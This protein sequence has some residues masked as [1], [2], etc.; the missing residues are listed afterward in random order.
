MSS[1]AK[2]VTAYIRETEQG[3]TPA[4]DWNVLRRTSFGVKPSYGTNESNEIGE[5]RMAQSTSAGTIDVGG[6][7][8]TMLR[9]GALDDFLA[10]CFGAEWRDN[11]LTMGDDNITF[12]IA[13]AFKDIGVQAVARGCRVGKME[14]TFPGDNDITVTTT[15]AGRDF[16]SRQ[17]DPFYTG[18]RNTADSV[19][20]YS[21]KDVSGLTMDGLPLEGVACVDNFSLSFDNNVQAQRCLGNG[22][23]YPGN[24]IA[25]KFAPT[26]SITLAWSPRAYEIWARQREKGTV[27]FAFTVRNA[28]GEYRFEFPRM[29][30]SGDWPDGG[31][32]D[33]VQVTLNVSAVVIPPKITRAPTQQ[34]K[35]S[36]TGKNGASDKPT[37]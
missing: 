37:A 20:N 11:T 16:E 17:G 25:T 7:V 3:K 14:F 10:S 12:S 21:F 23:G 19:P 4:G 15:F 22:T 5:S 35:G 24:Q 13:E 34:G 1:G 31:A 9:Y 36:D 27:A 26:G 30:I 32:Q 33:L 2:A 28:G 8:G 6:D 29:E 18:L